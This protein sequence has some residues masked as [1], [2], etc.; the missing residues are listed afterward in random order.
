MTWLDERE[1]ENFLAA[2]GHPQGIVPRGQVDVSLR[3]IEVSRK[4]I[5]SAK[6]EVGEVENEASKKTIQAECPPQLRA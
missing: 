3:E 4:S 1:L 5:R 6:W 2:A